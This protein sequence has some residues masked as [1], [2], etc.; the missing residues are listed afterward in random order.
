M[1]NTVVFLVDQI[2]LGLYGLLIA[3]VLWNLRRLWL[4]R[5]E[6]RAT[7]FE[8]ERD[9]AQYRQM[10]AVTNVIIMVQLGV[11]IL[12]VQQVMVPYLEDE[13]TLQQLSQQQRV[14]GDFSTPTPAPVAE[15]LDMEPAPPLGGDDA[16]VIPLT[17]TLTPTPVGTI[18]PNAPPASG[19]DSPQAFLQVP[20][21]GMRV[22]E[23]T[24][25]RGTA[26]TENFAYAKLE[27]KGPGT[28]DNFLVLEDLRS[29]VREVRDF[30]QFVPSGFEAGVYEFRLMV[31]DVSNTVRAGCMVNIYI[32]DPPVTPTPTPGPA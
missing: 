25:V 21:N 32:S 20:G 17:P 15:G 29:P 3:L 19:C 6:L 2:A 11:G 26:Y 30:S 13:L 9:L 27:I 16:P 4:A 23:P 28:F 14:D 7:Y 1:L 10:S 5:S 18:V 24:T 8:L 22:F 12:G 31:F